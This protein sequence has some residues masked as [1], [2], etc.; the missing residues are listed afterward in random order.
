ME[1]DDKELPTTHLDHLDT[2]RVPEQTRQAASHIDPAAE[3]RL[4]WKLDLVR[5]CLLARQ[6][7]EVLC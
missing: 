4:V 5:R 3:R 7:P 1:K 6:R 2:E